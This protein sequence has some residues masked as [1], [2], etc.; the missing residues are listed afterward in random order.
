LNSQPITGM[1]RGLLPVASIIG[2][3]SSL[4]GQNQFFLNTHK[5][6]CNA[7]KKNGYL[8]AGKRGIAGSHQSLWADDQSEARIESHRQT[9]EGRGES[10]LGRMLKKA[11]QQGRNELSLYK[12]WVG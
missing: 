9:I 7:L 5:D 8:E 2:P 3:K 6:Q 11:V 4:S 1:D 10:R 12:G